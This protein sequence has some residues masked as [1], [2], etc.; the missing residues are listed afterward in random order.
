V[1]Y[2]INETNLFNKLCGLSGVKYYTELITSEEHGTQAIRTFQ[3]Q[4][5]YLT[6]D[7]FLKIFSIDITY[8]ISVF[9]NRR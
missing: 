1:N 8:N 9:D 3:K 4:H 6:F 5:T 7:E 2:R